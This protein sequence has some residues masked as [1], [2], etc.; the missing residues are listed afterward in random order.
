LLAVTKS[1]PPEAVRA[2][3]EAGQI[4]FG[5]NRVQE[6]KAK[7]PLCPGHLRWHMIGHLQSNKCRDAVQLFE[8]IESVTVRPRAEIMGPRSGQDH[9]H[10]RSELAANLRFGQAARTLL[11]ELTDQ[12]AAPH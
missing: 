4:L 1:Q 7:I 8:M 5:E 2:A 6:A 12:R 10:T 3:V 9:A 11:A